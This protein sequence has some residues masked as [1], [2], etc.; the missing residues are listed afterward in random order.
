MTQIKRTRCGIEKV[1]QRFSALLTF[2]F[3]AFKLEIEDREKASV[4]AM[5]KILI[6]QAVAEEGVRELLSAGHEIKMGTG[7]TEEELMKEAA[8]CDAILLRTAVVSAKVL[9]AGKRLKIV[10]RHG[11]GYNNVDCRAAEELGIWVTNTPDATT[12]S[13]AE[14]TIAAI[15]S[16]S[17]R[18]L[19]MNRALKAGDFFYKNTHKGMDLAG[20]T[21]AIIGLGRIGQAVAKK[22][23][24]GLDM[25]VI[26]FAHGRKQEEVPEYIRLVDWETAFA[27]ADFV[28]LHVP[29]RDST[30]GFIGQP[31]FERMKKTAYLINCARGE[32]VR[33]KELI[34]AL[35]NGQIA[36]AF[37]DVF[38]QEPPAAEN[39]LLSMEQVTA[40][41]HMASNT[42]ECMAAM[43]Y[44]AAVQINRVL[45]GLEPDWP[46]NCPKRSLTE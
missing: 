42:E 23:H 11:A 41:P 5:A 37:C 40:T 36:G 35:E 19:E 13:V 10:A 1:S 25:K 39:P 7:V 9:E 2:S 29:L 32:V 16:A 30:R 22:A 44:Q 26:A 31:E 34:A 45:A 20:K 15:L 3:F 28:S 18:I 43:A 33:E 24:F 4:I 17:K 38:E 21:L 46:V 14:Y 12:N 27:E 6:P 8:D